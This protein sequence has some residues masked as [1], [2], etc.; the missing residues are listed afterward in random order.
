M[1]EKVPPKIATNP[2]VGLM[3]FLSLGNRSAIYS[4]KL[5]VTN[6]MSATIQRKMDIILKILPNNLYIS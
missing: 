4:S 1:K 2:D 3:F 6:E 5:E